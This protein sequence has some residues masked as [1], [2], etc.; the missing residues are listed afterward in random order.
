[1][2]DG[3]TLS[4][5]VLAESIPLTENTTLSEDTATSED[6]ASSEDVALSCDVLNGQ[7]NSHF[8]KDSPHPLN[9]MEQIKNRLSTATLF[10]FIYRLLV[11]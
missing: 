3:A 8:L 7:L 6:V 2:A 10:F 4:D 9:K 11:K 5:A 1:M